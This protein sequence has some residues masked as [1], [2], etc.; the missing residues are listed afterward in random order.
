LIRVLKTLYDIFLSADCV[1]ID[2]GP[3]LIHATG[4]FRS[5]KLGNICL[6]NAPIEEFN[7]LDRLFTSNQQFCIT[8]YIL[9]ELLYRV[10]SEFKLKEEG[11]EEFF[12]IY[13]T[14]LSNMEEI[15]IDKEK[16]IQD[17][18]IKFGLA[19]ISLLK[20][21]EETGAMILSSDEPFCRFCESRNIEFIEYKTFFLDNFLR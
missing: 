16:I 13:G 17:A 11:I 14:F 19:D 10:R 6:C 2:T 9:S 3:L 15:Q 8:P 4:A 5:D 18:G 7:F 20:A 1:V 12:Q 21:C